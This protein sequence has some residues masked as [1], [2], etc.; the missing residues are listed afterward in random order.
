M[1]W[2]FLSSV[3][4]DAYEEQAQGAI[5]EFP[6][7][8][9]R[10]KIQMIG[11][12]DDSNGQ[13]NM[14]MQEVQPTPDEMIRAGQR[15]AQEWHDILHA[16]G[17]ALELPKCTYQLLSWTFNKEGQPFAQG[18]TA[19][20]GIRVDTSASQYQQ[21]PEVSAH[22]AHKTLGH[23][24]DP[25][26]NQRRQLQVLLDKSNLAAAFVGKSPLSREEAWTYYF[27]I[28]LPSVGYPLPNCY[29]TKPELDRIQLKF[30][31]TII[32]KC[33]YNRKTKREII[34]GPAHLGGANFRPLYTEQGV[35]QVTTF[36][37]FWRS[38]GQA[39]QLLRIAVAWAQFVAGTSSSILIDVDTPLPQLETKWITS[40][41]SYLQRV[42]ARIELDKP[43]LTLCER[44][45]DWHI[46]DAILQSGQFSH[47]EI[48][49]LNYCRLYLQ[50]TTI[51]DLADAQGY[52]LDKHMAQGRLKHPSSSIMH[53][54]TVNQSRPADAQWSLWQ[55][56]NKLWSDDAG[57]LHQP[58]GKWVIPLSQQR[59]RWPAYATPN[60]Q[61]FV[62]VSGDTAQ[63][64]LHRI[65]NDPYTPKGWYQVNTYTESNVHLPECAYPVPLVQGQD[66]TRLVL[67]GIR[68]KRLPWKAHHIT[69]WRQPERNQDFT[70]YIGMREAWEFELL[71]HINMEFDA[72]TTCHAMQDGFEAACDGSVVKDAHGSFGWIISTRSGK[73]LARAFGP[74]RGSKPSSYRAEAY[75]VLSFL[76]FLIR[77]QDFCSTSIGDDWSVT[78]D[79][80]ALVNTLNHQSSEDQSPFSTRSDSQD[81]AAWS[82]IPSHDVEDGEVCTRAAP[83]ATNTS[84]TIDPDWDVINEI[85][86]IRE[87]G[88]IKIGRISHIPGHQ[89]R[90]KRYD[91][92]SLPAQLNVDA[93]ALAREYQT[94]Y[95]QARPKVLLFPHAG[96]HIHTAKGTCTAHI[97]KMLRC[98][99]HEEPLASYI[100]QRNCWDLVIFN[101]IDWD[102]HGHAIKKNNRQRIHITKLVHDILPTNK[103]VYRRD[104]TAQLCIEC[105]TRQVE[106]RDHVL[107]C[108]HSSRAR[109]RDQFLA[110]IE[111]KGV[112]L[113]SDPQLLNIL[114]QGLHWWLQGN[115]DGYNGENIPEKYKR[116]VRQQ[117]AIGWRQV[118]NGR[119]SKEWARLQADYIWIQ[120]QRARDFGQCRGNRGS[121]DDS[122]RNDYTGARWTSDMIDEI[123]I[124]WRIVW[125]LRNATIHGHDQQTRSEKLHQ[126]N[127]QRLQTIYDNRENLEP[128]VRELLFDTIDDHRRQ[129]SKHSLHNWLV[130]HETTFIL[131]AKNVGSRAIRGVKSI[132]EYFKPRASSNN[133]RVNDGQQHPMSS[134]I[135]PANN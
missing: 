93:D 60:G 57:K 29:F 71:Q 27:A 88:G 48:R 21:I 86:W 81:W 113:R 111:V 94:L 36:L 62:R 74:V 37:R 11:Y 28:Y 45:H 13:T 51:S 18:I 102:A 38:P 49:Q 52:Y 118:F 109:W 8:S 114:T 128:S 9:G 15:D 1:I 78:S 73:R 107:R 22:T 70:Q 80:M 2:C 24:K 120:K 41:R 17:G 55:K 14:F 77:I 130:V 84:S 134:I 26:G 106:D 124:Q 16:S 91:E 33:G 35:G 127:N 135:R 115:E 98:A 126:R 46:M 47:K 34:Y 19:T 23:Y 31:S 92:L 32:A 66:G 110:A 121:E 67:L 129:N 68:D 75:G 5:Y 40:L 56:A 112:K 104:P 83:T 30:M 39:G 65:I 119:M 87:S 59:R 4:F 20:N 132:K 10:F 44:E 99:E 50:C 105:Q 97:P 43:Y 42:G 72:F 58:L 63:F 90:K 108:P 101:S 54:H 82:E 3:L 122:W 6:D 64:N 25:A 89:D 76:Q 96:A 103:V 12:V 116:L 69:P 95:G 131:S 123:W 117:N 85:N 61:L 133:Q 100:R 53:W 7:R 125:T 79:N